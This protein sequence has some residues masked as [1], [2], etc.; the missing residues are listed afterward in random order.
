MILLKVE[1]NTLPHPVNFILDD[2]ANIPK[3]PGMDNKITV[4]RSRGIFFLK[5]RSFLDAIK[6]GGTAPVPSSQ[7][8]INQAIID[9]IVKSSKLGK[10]IEIDIPEI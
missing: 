2:F 9:G 8:I 10:E 5:I 4:S 6:N 1:K 7:I 3:I